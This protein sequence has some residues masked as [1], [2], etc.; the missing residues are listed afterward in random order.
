M[1]RTTFA[2][3]LLALSM[4][5]ITR[6]QVQEEGAGARSL[7][8]GAFD[9]LV[10]SMR[11][12]FAA[13]DHALLVGRKLS[14]DWSLA[15]ALL[16]RDIIDGQPPSHWCA[17]LD[18]GYGSADPLSIQ[19]QFVPP[20]VAM[21]CDRLRSH[22]HELEV[23][24]LAE[25]QEG[26]GAEVPPA[27]SW[28][29]LFTSTTTRM[30][31]S[32]YEPQVSLRGIDFPLPADRTLL[33]WD[34]RSMRVRV[35]DGSAHLEAV[36][37]QAV[38]TL[39]NL[40][41]CYDLFDT[42][43]AW[44]W[45]KRLD[46]SGHE[47]RALACTHGED[48]HIP[49]TATWTRLGEGAWQLSIALRPAVAERSA[50]FTVEQVGIDP[51]S[52]R[53]GRLTARVPIVEEGTQLLIR[54]EAP[55]E[56]DPRSRESN[57]NGACFPQRMSLLVDQREIA[58]ATLA[59][60][61]C[62]VVRD[63]AAPDPLLPTGAWA[64]AI[65]RTRLAQESPAVPDPYPAA[66]LTSRW[67]VDVVRA[68]LTANSWVFAMRGDAAGVIEAQTA[69]QVLRQRAGLGH[70]QLAALQTL[71]ESFTLADAPD[72]VIS[73]VALRH[74]L[75]ASELADEAL[76]PACLAATGSG[77]FW[78]ALDIARAA[79]SR[80]EHGDTTAS[81]WHAVEAELLHWCDDPASHCARGADPAVLL[82]A[83]RYRLD[84]PSIS[85][86][87][88]P[89]QPLSTVDGRAAGIAYRVV[90]ACLSAPMPPMPPMITHDHR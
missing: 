53:P 65:M 8:Y 79:L 37:P 58:S 55:S 17:H 36:W 74:A 60:I 78:A 16:I 59:P 39:D 90:D 64:D 21:G 40:G 6:A 20:E 32:W 50:G 68:R 49:R 31:T 80:L 30:R 51:N 14:V 13:E 61:Q 11:D 42:L 1:A 35:L 5:V 67:P 47:A 82:F 26:T 38:P 27:I 72:N 84:L 41:D 77:R 29:C 7:L 15:P 63:H 89:R 22:F 85:Q 75:A 66:L 2:A 48:Q 88:Q 87:V 71:A 69:A 76:V 10:R 45:S 52:P 86:R 4:A 46:A 43:R 33:E 56:P 73:A 3:F 57:L 54:F 19:P 25:R 23:E 9:E 62:G 44:H 24:Y 81:R 28:R 18:D 83:E 70:H 34:A 12:Q